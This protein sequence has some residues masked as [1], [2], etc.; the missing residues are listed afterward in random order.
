MITKYFSVKEK[1]IETPKYD[2]SFV[3]ITQDKNKDNELISYLQKEILKAYRDPKFYE[4]KKQSL[5]QTELMEYIKNNVIPKNE[6]GFDCA[7]RYGDFGEI[8][9]TLVLRFIYEKESFNKLRWK[10]NPDKS[11]LGTDIV[12]FDSIDNPSEIIYSEVKTLQNAL[13]KKPIT[14]K[15][16]NG[17]KV[18]CITGFITVIAYNS[19]A[20]DI[21]SSRETILDFI[22]RLYV[23]KQDYQKAQL[24]SD[25]VDQKRKINKSFKIFVITD[26]SIKEKETNEKKDFLQTLTDVANI[27]NKVSPLSITY[28]FID[29]IKE[30]VT[31]TW[32][33]IVPNGIKFIEDSTL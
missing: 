21:D 16:E 14:W 20:K 11:V 22:S 28:I 3:C 6:K 2:F 29:K 10:Y 13:E 19:L 27:Q 8:F 18:P 1:E 33:T 5:S 15:K 26:S 4:I 25:L 9:V 31:D 23:E 30:L 32:D 7:V 17:K 24:F 12:S